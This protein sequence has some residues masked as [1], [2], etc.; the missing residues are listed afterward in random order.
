MQQSKATGMVGSV[1]DETFRALSLLWDKW[2]YGGDE[3]LLQASSK[4]YLQ[5]DKQAK[6]KE[7]L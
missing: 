7:E 6:S 5:V 2:K 3:S 1:E 4:A